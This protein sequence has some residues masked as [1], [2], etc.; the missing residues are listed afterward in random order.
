MNI[1][2]KE[3]DLPDFGHSK[4]IPDI[5]TDIYEKRIKKLYEKANKDWV[6]VYGD[7][8]HFANL[9]YL[10]EFDPRWEEALLIIGPRN[11]KYFLLG[12]EGMIYKDVIKPE[13][14][15]TFCQSF[16]LLGQDRS[17]TP[18]LDQLLKSIGISDSDSIG[19]VGWKYLEDYEFDNKISFFVPSFIIDT[20]EAVIGGREKIFDVTDVLMHPTKGLRTYNEP[21]QIAVYEWGASRASRDL[22]NIVKG[23]KP[24]IT[25]LEACANMGYSGEPLTAHMNYASGSGKLISIQ[26]PTDKIIEKGDAIFTALAYRGGLSCRA[27]LCE[28]ENDTFIEEWAIPYYKGI[29][30]WYESVKVGV[31]GGEIY[32]Q[33]NDVLE[34]GGM[35]SLLN[36]GHLSGVDEWLHTQF[37]PGSDEPVLSGM[38]IQCDIIPDQLDEGIQLNSEDPIV[39]ADEE[40]RKEIAEEYPEMWSRILARQKFMREKLGINISDDI[41]PL[42]ST[43]GYYAPLFLSYNKVLA[44]K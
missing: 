23:T 33:I 6:I 1:E 3:I 34:D 10:T 30:K 9:H 13:V 16:S 42:S 26:S 2:W 22:W 19:I 36:P 41:L 39:I 8:E 31:K 21:A 25:E 38:A 18:R 28:N 29:V 44:V 20:L 5:P 4:D 35:R 24:G 32:T 27:G 12:N 43:P 40:L 17:Q 15:I 11:Q 37:R 7:R 14:D